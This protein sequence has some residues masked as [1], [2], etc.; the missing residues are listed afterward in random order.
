MQFLS[1][2]FYSL[3]YFLVLFATSIGAPCNEARILDV[4]T[5]KIKDNRA[6]AE[7]SRYI[8][9]FKAPVKFSSLP[10]VCAILHWIMEQYQL[11]WFSLLVTT[12]N[13]KPSPDR[14]DGKY[15]KSNDCKALQ[16][17]LPKVARF[18][19]GVRKA[20]SVQERACRNQISCN[21][22]DILNT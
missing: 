4:V 17:M 21:R 1:K 22:F 15:P 2:Y 6:I 14:S 18:W 9:L 20:W 3:G 8:D 12:P 7:S 19:G 13:E 5:K 16:A 11:W 10:D